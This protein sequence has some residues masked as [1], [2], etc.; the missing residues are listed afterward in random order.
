[1][2]YR[3]ADLTSFYTSYPSR[4]ASIV[5]CW[6]RSSIIYNCSF[7]VYIVNVYLY[8][9]KLIHIRIN[10]VKNNPSY[11]IVEI[12]L[13]GDDATTRLSYSPS[14]WMFDQVYCELIIIP[15]LSMLCHHNVTILV[16]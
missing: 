9:Y 12:S 8:N 1:M 16:I 2:F 15:I 3:L 10:H 5:P 4:I 11:F 6:A 13:I 7:F 14:Q